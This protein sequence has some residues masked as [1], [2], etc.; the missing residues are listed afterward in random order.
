MVQEQCGL[1]KPAHE[2]RGSHLRRNFTAVVGSVTTIASNTAFCLGHIYALPVDQKAARFV[3]HFSLQLRHPHP[4][5]Q[6]YRRWKPDQ[7]GQP[8]NASACGALHKP[9]DIATPHTHLA[10]N[11]YTRTH[12][13]P[14]WPSRHDDSNTPG[15]PSA[16][17]RPPPA[18]RPCRCR[19]QHH[20]C[21][22]LLP[23][24]LPL[25][26]PPRLRRR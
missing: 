21:P 7:E 14:P 5:L 24:Q 19:H 9:A 13:P 12:P 11:G 8:L 6:G 3:Q 17:S 20:H 4:R 1:T 18:V 10:D 23:L 22:L 15:A 26:L 25:P 2:T 16:A